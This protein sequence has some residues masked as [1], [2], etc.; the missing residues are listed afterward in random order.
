MNKK[1]VSVIRG[2]S[3]EFDIN[4]QRAELIARNKT[5]LKELAAI[6]ATSDIIDFSEM[7]EFFHFVLEANE[8]KGIPITRIDRSGD[9]TLAS[10]L[11]WPDMPGLRTPYM[12]HSLRLWIRFC[13]QW[14]IRPEWDGIVTSLRKF[15]ETPLE[16]YWI[17]GEEDDAPALLLRINS[18]TA[19][20]DI[21]GAWGQV[22]SLQNEMWKKQEKRTNFA[23]D[24]CW[25]DL[26]KLHALKPKDIAKLWAK[27]FPKEIDL[28]V[29]RRMKE[30]IPES[31]LMG[32][33]PDD[34]ELLKAIKVGFLSDQYRAEYRAQREY[35]L[36]GKTL[37]KK[38]NSPFA[39]AIKKAV[40]RMEQQVTEVSI[41]SLKTNMM[42]EQVLKRGKAITR[43]S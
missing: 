37:G 1:I 4:A 43:Q 28:L 33:R 3:R 25:Y 32:R 26:T 8:K 38:F 14:N 7:L 22:E 21:R 18:W 6:R 17:E 10:H 9:T 19:L 13:K 39:D 20:K 15:I 5:F 11:V 36:K 34:G 30:E 16:F 42:L 27:Y 41:T 31:H 40:G 24:L 29:V 23:R 2:Y 35:Y 12:E